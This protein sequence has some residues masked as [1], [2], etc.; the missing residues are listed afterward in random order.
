VDSEFG[1]KSNLRRQVSP[2][3]TAFQSPVIPSMN[4]RPL[5]YRTDL[6]FPAFDGQIVDRGEY[7]V[8]RTP[9]NP[10]FAAT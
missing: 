6:F 9:S 4:I 3:K 1:R 8:V 7:V 5:G 10:T 2:T